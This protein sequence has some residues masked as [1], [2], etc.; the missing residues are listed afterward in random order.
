MSAGK[1]NF[2]IVILKLSCLFLSFNA[3]AQFAP[4]PPNLNST[5]IF[6]DDVQIS[7]WA[8]DIIL[9][10]S[11]QNIADTSLGKVTVGTQNNVLGKANNTFVSLGDGGSAILKFPYTI[12]N[13]NG[14]DFA[15]FENGFA[16]TN[17]LENYLFMEL[18][19]VEVSQNGVDF[20]RFPAISNLDTNIGLGGFGTSDCSKV[21][22]LA[23]KYA[24]NYGT[25]FDLEELGLDSIVSIKII[26]VVGSLD[27]AFCSFDSQGNKI[28]DPFPTPFPS[29]GFDL[30]AVAA[31]NQKNKIE[32][33]TAILENNKDVLKIFP[34]PSPLNSQV[35]LELAS[36]KEA[37]YKII[38]I[39]GKQVLSSSFR[40]ETTFSTQNFA[41]GIYFIVLNQE[42]SVF[43]YKFMVE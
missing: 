25:P 3:F 21:N 13:E 9:N 20:I 17:D 32:Y 42:S 24:L 11:W 29:S 2:F 15:V 7:F 27:S 31:L 33:P 38:D 23:G 43:C 6:K 10:I 26:D 40:K 41:Q 19:F 37:I 30:N 4:A 16:Q 1:K 35:N 14:F 22:N 8:N 18:A 39:N 12:Y 5:A 34:N 36:D 28:S